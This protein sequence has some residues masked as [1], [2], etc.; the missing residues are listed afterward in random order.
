MIFSTEARNG[1]RI[2]QRAGDR[3]RERKLDEMGAGWRKSWKA[4]ARELDLLESEKVLSRKKK[5][6]WPKTRISP[7]PDK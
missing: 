1:E 4:A 6:S 2:P 5:G 7:V 3:Q